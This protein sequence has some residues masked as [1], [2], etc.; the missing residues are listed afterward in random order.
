MHPEVAELAG[1]LQEAIDLLLTHGET[2]WAQWLGLS[3]QRIQTR[4]MRDVEH[5]FF[6]HTAVRRKP[7]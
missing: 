2:H 3:A 4:E 1:L 6:L 7:S 5:S